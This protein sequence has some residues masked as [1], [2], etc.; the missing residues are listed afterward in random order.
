MEQPPGSIDDLQPQ[1]LSTSSGASVIDLTRKGEGCDAASVDALQVVSSSNRCPNSGASNPGLASDVLLQAG[2]EH[3]RPDVALS[4]TTVTVSYVSRSHVFSPHDSLSQHLPLCG[5]PAISKLPLNPPGDSD[6]GLRETGVPLDQHYSEKVDGPVDLATQ[7]E[8]FQTS[9]QAQVGPESF[10]SSLTR[11]TNEVNGGVASPDW[12]EDE[13]AL[14][15]EERSLPRGRAKALENGQIDSCSRS[16]VCAES[17]PE[18]LAPAAEE[19]ED[20]GGAEVLFLMSKTKDSAVLPDGLAARDPCSLKR[21]YISPLD[22]PVSPSPTSQ[23]DVEDVFVLPQASSSPSGDNPYLEMADEAA[24]D[25]VG[26]RG[27]DPP[28]A[29]ESSDKEKE[30][31]QK[32][33]APSVPLIDLT[34]DF[35][36]SDDVESKTA[37]SHM[38]GNAK[39]LQRALES[40]KLPARSG[41]GTRPE[42]ATVDVN[43]NGCEVS[44]CVRTGRQ[45]SSPTVG[46]SKFTNDEKNDSAP[47]RNG[48]R[49]AKVSVAADRAAEVPVKRGKADDGNTDNHRD[50]T[51]DS[52][53]NNSLKPPKSPRLAAQ[54]NSPLQ[55]E[56]LSPPLQPSAAER[57]SPP[58]PAE[59]PKRSRAGAKGGSAARKTPPTAKRKGGAS[60]R[61]RR[62][63]RMQAPAS[64]MFSP[65]EPEIKLRYVNYKE[66]KRESRVDNFSPFVHVQR[67][68]QQQPSLCAVVN[69]PEEVGG[70]TQPRRGQPGPAPQAAQPGGFVSSAVPGTSC[71]QPGR[72]TAHGQHRRALVCCLCGLPANA[73]DLGDLHGPYY[74]EGFQPAAKGG[75]VGSEGLRGE[76]GDEDDDSDASS[77][78]V[79]TRRRKQAVPPRPQRSGVPLKG[80]GLRARRRR[81]ADGPAASPAKRARPDGGSGA[82]SSAEDWY[83][84]PLLPAEPCEFWLHEDCGIWST[85]VF[86]VRGRVYGLEEAVRAAQETVRPHPEPAPVE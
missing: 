35:C 70:A 65:K 1:D 32:Q 73:M 48:T 66:E 64:N 71:L 19:D 30:P 67:R 26:A 11:D 23:D 74:P 17:S 38:N 68:P 55:P 56:G 45:A 46:D 34:D 15:G 6:A 75:A 37:T 76:R 58:P 31:V 7:T 20:T 52:E 42:A 39:T 78:S 49:K 14:G 2:E 5:V 36:S 60:P 16:G 84:A 28:D 61:K 40:K 24:R 12:D 3:I 9:S 82:A 27:A 72:V 47:E 22:D 51:S 43:S 77:R 8:L 69:Y 25:G 86:L 53:A 79:R 18:T 54:K 44:G 57:N 62:R 41:R 63:R 85:G 59:S 4:R 33:K 13:R 80:R 10:G 21:D 50:S 29:A 81:S 83:S